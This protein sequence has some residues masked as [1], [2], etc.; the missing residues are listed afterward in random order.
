MHT[1]TEKYF[2]KM[3]SYRMQ[4]SN[5]SR[6]K[7]FRTAGYKETVEYSVLH[8]VTIESVVEIKAN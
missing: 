4:L 7:G 8:K 1:E 6:I 5:S 3:N 2:S